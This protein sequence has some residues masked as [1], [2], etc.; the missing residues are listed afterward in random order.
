MLMQ[1]MPEVQIMMDI[2]L[3]SGKL[4]I[5]AGE[6]IWLGGRFNLLV[7]EEPEPLHV[8]RRDIYLEPRKPICLVATWREIVSTGLFNRMVEHEFT[9]RWDIPREMVIPQKPASG[10]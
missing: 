9:G 5:A 3:P 1:S 10:P 4:L 7:P 8:S 6:V 2:H